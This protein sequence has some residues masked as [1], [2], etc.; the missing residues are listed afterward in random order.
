[1][2]DQAS[3]LKLV[4]AF[5]AC[6]F[7]ICIYIEFISTTNFLSLF[8]FIL[9]FTIV[10]SCI[11]LSK[12][13]VI[14][15]LTVFSLMFSGYVIGGLYYA[16]SDGF[17]GKFVSF[18]NLKREVAEDYLI[19]AIVFAIVC[20]IFFVGGYL[21][22]SR[23]LEQLR[24]VKKS[25]FSSFISRN[26]IF[27]C[28]PLLFVGFSYW[29]WV[30]QTIA[31]GVIDALIF[32]QVFPHL[33]EE[34]EISILPY[35]LYYAGSNIWLIGMLLN[36][37]SLKNKTSLF[38]FFIVALVG[39]VISISTARI[40]IS[41]T[42]VLAQLVFIHFLI[43][44]K[45]NQIVI[46]CIGLF[47]AAFIVFFLRELSN[48]YFL[49]NETESASFGV[50][51]SIVGGGN[52][53][54]LQQLVIIFHSFEIQY[55]LLGASYLDW[56]NNSVGVMFGLEPRSVGLLVHEKYIPSSSGA[57][58][59][60]A[61]GEAFANFN[62]LAPIFMLFVGWILSWTHNF[63][64]RTQNVF[65][66]FVYSNFLVCFVFMYPKVDSTM[67]TNFF[68]GAAPTVVVLLGFYLFFCL[69]P[70]KS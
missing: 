67:I 24:S 19:S 47:F 36:G 26:Y 1:M 31:G 69:L 65:L 28:V 17:F 27:L 29:V 41:L 35:L 60:G 63:F 4:V 70:K 30:C 37:T 66:I 14:N 15:P 61:I 52:V 48:Y 45:R 55:S 58:T 50:L 12:G 57:P 11:Y 34:H 3:K 68:W 16:T 59:P 38:I 46:T 49:N 8:S 6:F 21:C 23:R 5:A 39:L 9:G 44:S 10:L 64:I 33:I 51:D 56:L 40:T 43:P 53:T 20:Y 13:G 7:P 2:I 32:F 18:V 54:D 42:Y 62:V 22:Q 25:D